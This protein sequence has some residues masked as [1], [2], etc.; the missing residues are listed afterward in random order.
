MSL[1][2]GLAARTTKK[3]VTRLFLVTAGAGAMTWALVVAPVFWPESVIAN[4]ASA[5]V[6]GETFKP[7][8]LAA[9][10][11][12]TENSGGR[13]LRSSMLG[14][15]AVIRLR[16]AEDSLRG[17]SPDL[18]KERLESLQ[19]IVDR[20][21]QNAPED[22]LLWLTAFW[23][24][25]TRHGLR[26]DGL[27]FLRMSYDLG[28]YEGWIAIRRNGAALTAY[29]ILPSD[30]AE[31]AIAEFV[32]MVRWGLVNEAAAI[33]AGPGRQLRNI[34][35]ARLKDLSEEQR[36]A[37]ANAI[38]GR[39]LDDVPVPGIAPPVLSVPMP[40]MPPDL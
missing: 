3:N 20:T 38:Y 24:D 14:K 23:L 18:A 19:Q 9:V 4:V 16:Q 12:L 36:R 27:R 33:A 1:V 21:F 25:S 10:E 37:F 7:D 11:A 15:A 40:V 35:F 32:G 28:P 39:E 31:R 5:V 22:S 13:E 26:P 34:L 2:G 29:S 17:G 30:L 8:V 6:A